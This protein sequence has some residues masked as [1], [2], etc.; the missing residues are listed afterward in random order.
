MK[1]PIIRLWYRWLLAKHAKGPEYQK[2]KLFGGA[3]YVYGE[4]K[5]HKLSVFVNH[6]LHAGDAGRIYRGYRHNYS[7]VNINHSSEISPSLFLTP[8]RD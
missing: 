6:T 1:I 7:T 3:S 8:R 4:K 5:N 2:T